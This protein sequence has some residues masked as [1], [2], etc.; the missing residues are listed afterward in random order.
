MAILV[1]LGIKHRQAVTAKHLDFG[2]A[3]RLAGGN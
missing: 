2:A 3:N 1:G